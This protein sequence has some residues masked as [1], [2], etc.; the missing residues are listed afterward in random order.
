[1]ELSWGKIL[2]KLGKLSFTLSVK[3]MTHKSNFVTG[4]MFFYGSGNG[5]ISL[6]KNSMN[7][8]HPIWIKGR[9]KYRHE[10][11]ERGIETFFLRNK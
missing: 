4:K 9:G 10:T 8:E 11:E 1:M 2:G 7:I 3:S 5:K 6:V